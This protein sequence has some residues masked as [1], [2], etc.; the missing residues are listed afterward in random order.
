MERKTEIRLQ[1]VSVDEKGRLLGS[2]RGAGGRSGFHS[3]TKM[4]PGKGQVEETCIARMLGDL[5]QHP[6]NSP[7]PTPTKPMLSY[8][9]GQKYFHK[10]KVKYTI[11]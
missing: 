10:T 11:M 2:L 6:R 9:G 7:V 3:R 8:R 5:L 4:P 1:E